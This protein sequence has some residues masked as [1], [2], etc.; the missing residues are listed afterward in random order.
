M[1][2]QVITRFE[3]E[4][5]L[6]KDAGVDKALISALEQYHGIRGT[7]YFSLIHQGVRFHQFVGVIR[8]GRWT[9]KVLPKVD[10][11]ASLN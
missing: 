9:V 8:V 7:P 3:H 6:A 10:L 11:K 1:G 2:S 5:L 4:K